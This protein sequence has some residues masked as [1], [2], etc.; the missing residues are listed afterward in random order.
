RSYGDWSS[1]V[2]SSDLLS[3]ISFT[4]MLYL[5]FAA[6]VSL[7]LTPL[8]LLTALTF[9]VGFISILLGLLAEM[10]VR[11]YFESQGRTA[12][13]VRAQFRSEER[14]VGK[15]WRSRC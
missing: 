14:R 7:I 9:L 13:L 10:L 4:L 3:A 2:C 12:Y 5:K 8:P 1:D 15:G 6:G 11:I